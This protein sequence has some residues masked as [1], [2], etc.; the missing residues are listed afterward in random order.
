MLRWRKSRA[1]SAADCGEI[2]PPPW[3]K[4]KKSRSW[5]RLS[6][7]PESKLNEGKTKRPVCIHHCSRSSVALWF[8]VYKRRK[9][10]LTLTCWSWRAA[11]NLTRC[12]PD[13]K[14]TNMWHQGNDD[15]WNWLHLNSRIKTLKHKP[16]KRS[17]LSSAFKNSPVMGECILKAVC[18]HKEQRGPVSWKRFFTWNETFAKVKLRNLSSGLGND[19]KLRTSFLQWVSHDKFGAVS[20]LSVIIRNK[21]CWSKIETLFV[22]VSLQSVKVSWLLHMCTQAASDLFGQVKRCET[23][24]NSRHFVNL[25][26]SFFLLHKQDGLSPTPTA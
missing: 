15:L 20:H 6:A 1:A 7:L 4:C 24:L 12:L 16:T 5:I 19:V 25:K 14:H 18:T 22:Y 26:P 10:G 11:L 8:A 21:T 17:L 23:F 2:S 9:L 3:E 13:I